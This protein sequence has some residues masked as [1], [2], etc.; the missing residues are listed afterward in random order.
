MR[1]GLSVGAPFPHIFSP[2]INHKGFISDTQRSVNSGKV[3]K[4][5]L[6]IKYYIVVVTYIFNK[7]LSSY[8]ITFHI[9]QIHQQ[10]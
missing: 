9:H 3:L 10:P 4:S 6:F 7:E 1:D 2:I 8:V 5:V